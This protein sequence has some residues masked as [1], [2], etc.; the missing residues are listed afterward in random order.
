MS[1]V[2]KDT[3]HTQA[4]ENLLITGHTGE[5]SLT[6]ITM[7]PLR[8]FWLHTGSKCNLNCPLCLESAHSR[9]QR[10]EHPTF[11]EAEHHIFEALEQGAQRLCFTGGEPFVYPEFIKILGAALNYRPCLVLTNATEPIESYLTELAS[12]AIRM[13]PLHIRVSIDYPFESAH[14]RIRG[15]GAFQRTLRNC[16]RLE[17]LGH[18]ISIARR[19][20]PHENAHDVNAQ[21]RKIFHDFELAEST[22]L[23][24]FP[25]LSPST[26]PLDAQSLHM[27]GKVPT[28]QE[29]CASLMCTHSMIAAKKYGK[30]CI[31]PCFLTHDDESFLL[32]QSLAEASEHTSIIPNHRRCQTCLAQ[33]QANE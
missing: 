29:Q 1:F 27:R 22:P 8:D 19:Q 4:T 20:S 7:G 6:P 10:V 3:T 14:D 13:H 5:T 25:E 17:R 30:F 12:F 15:K 31:Y 9:S 24:S 11:Q 33:C 2:K 32:G 21:Y 16:A 23:V 18:H 26:L 28:K